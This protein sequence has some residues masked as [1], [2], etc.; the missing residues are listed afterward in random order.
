[1]SFVLAAIVETVHKCAKQEWQKTTKAGK[2]SE[3]DSSLLASTLPTAA[4]Q[5]QAICPTVGAESAKKP[6]IPA[7][8]QPSADGEVKMPATTPPASKSS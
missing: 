7:G 1:M 3:D 6:K 4:R 8:G 5:G 2:R